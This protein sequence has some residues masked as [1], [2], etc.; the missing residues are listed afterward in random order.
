MLH[1]EPPHV[2][3]VSDLELGLATV[4]ILVGVVLTALILPAFV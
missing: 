1:S 2:T 4:L 3:H